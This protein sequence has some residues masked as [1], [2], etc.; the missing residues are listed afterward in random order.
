M[1]IQFLNISSHL[2]GTAKTVSSVILVPLS[3]A[4]HVPGKPGETRV[5]HS[6]LQ[7]T[8]CVLPPAANYLLPAGDRV[9][10]FTCLGTV[11]TEEKHG[12]AEQ[13]GSEGTRHIP[14]STLLLSSLLSAG[15]SLEAAGTTNSVGR[16]RQMFLHLSIW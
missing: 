3:L 1:S 8:C 12:T 6:S 9:Q 11:K 4:Q 2:L 10:S 13:Q 16:G 5:A 14:R 15:P 7:H